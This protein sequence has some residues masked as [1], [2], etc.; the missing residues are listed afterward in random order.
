[1]RVGPVDA[2]LCTGYLKS[3][4]TGRLC[5]REAVERAVPVVL[6]A[7]KRSSLVSLQD[8]LQVSLTYDI[9]KVRMWQV[10]AI[11]HAFHA[12]L[13]NHSHREGFYVKKPV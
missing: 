9:V 10:V 12:C 13:D 4:L 6:S 11:R 8:R 1:M 5:C 3:S 7:E 2:Q